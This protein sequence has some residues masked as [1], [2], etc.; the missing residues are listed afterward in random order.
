MALIR[1]WK[2]TLRTFLRVQNSIKIKGKKTQYLGDTAILLVEPECK[3]HKTIISDPKIE[4]AIL[5]NTPFG[6]T[7][8]SSSPQLS[9]VPSLW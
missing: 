2:I 1:N 3:A 4:Y 8:R 5:T 6:S 7:A 9:I